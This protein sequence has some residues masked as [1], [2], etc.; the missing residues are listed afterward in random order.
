MAA[1]DVRRGRWPTSSTRPLVPP[2]MPSVVYRADDTDH[3]DRVYRGEVD[4][5]T[6]G[7]EG[8]PNAVRIA[9]RVARLEGAAAGCAASSGMGIIA[10]VLLTLLDRTSHWIASDQLY[11]RTLR[12]AREAFPRLGIAT[13]VVPA[14][15]LDAFRSAIRSNT[16]LVL[17]EVVSNPLIQ[18]VDIVALAELCRKHGILLVVDNTFPTP[19]GCNPLELG[20]D[21]V[22]HSATKMLAG[23]SDCMVGIACG[24]RDLIEQ[25]AD[26]IATWGMNA[27][28]FDCW[29][30]DRGLETLRLRYRQA[31]RNAQTLARALR[32]HPRVRRVF[33][34]ALP[35]HPSHSVAQRVLGEHPGTMLAFELAGNRTEVDRFLRAIGD[36]VPFAPTLGDVCTLLTHPLSSSHRRLTAEQAARAGIAEG[37][38]RV[39]CG[40]E[41]TEPLVE[42]FRHALDSLG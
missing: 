39:S 7:R 34:P 10:A 35:E 31:E 6:Y 41:E 18:V 20:A 8:N 36:A 25:V 26:T 33:Y 38:L 16:R 12:L 19:I 21:L 2:I 14:A 37:L 28:P 9:E 15:D 4:G 3:L 32:E 1:F 24:P 11:G 5:F 40:V 23:H 13:T 17:V 30:L 27:S 29:L 42:A 22:V